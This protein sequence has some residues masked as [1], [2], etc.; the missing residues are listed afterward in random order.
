ME[1]IALV[2]NLLLRHLTVRAT[3]EIRPERMEVSTDIP[4]IISPRKMPHPGL[5]RRKQV[6]ELLETM[7]GFRH[8]ELVCLKV[9]GSIRRRE[10]DDSVVPSL[11]IHLATDDAAVIC[12][13]RVRYP[14][15]RDDI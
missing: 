6:V 12:R 13:V 4:P 10:S 14:V 7:I 11:I 15:E 2:P 5:L 3:N 9:A 8:G 1:I